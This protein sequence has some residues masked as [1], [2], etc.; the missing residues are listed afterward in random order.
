MRSVTLICGPP[1]SGKTTLA[2]QLAADGGEVLDRDEMAKALGSPREWMHDESFV[3]LAEAKMYT[4]MARLTYSRTGRAYVVRSLP[5]ASDRARTARRLRAT[6]TLLDPGQDECL[7]RAEADGRPE[8]T[9]EAI[10]LWY[11]RAQA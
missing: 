8:G 2:R 9:A 4:E 5:H 7:R 3:D 6:V 11:A 1:C 10:R